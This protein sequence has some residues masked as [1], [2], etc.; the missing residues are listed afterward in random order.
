MIFEVIFDSKELDL[1]PKSFIA[2]L[3]CFV[4]VTLFFFFSLSFG[5]F[6]NVQLVLTLV[7]SLLELYLWVHIYSMSASFSA[8]PTGI[9]T[10]PR[11]PPFV[12]SILI[13]MITKLIFLWY[14]LIHSL[15]IHS[16]SFKHW[17]LPHLSAQ[18]FS[19]SYIL[20]TIWFYFP[21]RKKI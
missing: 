11:S 3:T 5:I 8:K 4:P 10:L 6:Q 9:L 16:L 13:S 20:F 15:L 19:K 14:L 1:Q 18:L 21:P 2:G 12:N 7:T 17:A